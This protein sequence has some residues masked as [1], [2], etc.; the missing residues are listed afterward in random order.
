MRFLADENVA[1]DL[2]AWLRA[3]GHDVL[4]AAEAQ[5]GASDL[6]WAI[7][8][9][10]EQRIILTQDKDFGELVFRDGQT[11]HGIILLRLDE[12]PVSAILARL[13]AVWAVVEANPSGRFIVITET[14][15]RVRPLP[16]AP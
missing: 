4:Y 12:L 7:R 11:T 3:G 8:A 10:Q 1:R 2:V 13:Q 5:A 9:E 6:S 15:V 16:Q 14:K